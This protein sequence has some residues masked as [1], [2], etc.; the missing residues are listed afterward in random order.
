MT[1]TR[2]QWLEQ[3]RFLSQERFSE[4]LVHRR[5][6]RYGNQR[7]FSELHGHRIEGEAI[8]ELK[9]DLAAG[10]GER[11]AR[12]AAQY[13]TPGRCRDARQTDALPATAWFP[14]AVSAKPCRPRGA[15]SKNRHE[16]KQAHPL[17]PC[18]PGSA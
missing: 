8:A 17:S 18:L 7:I 5:S 14:I 9:A 1:S 10:E 13:S 16:R 15:T 6:A 12:S 3:S 11:A 4:S 2:L